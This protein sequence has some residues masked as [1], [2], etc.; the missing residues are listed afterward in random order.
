MNITNRTNN[1]T[2]TNITNS[3][4]NTSITNT[5][6]K[7]VKKT[8]NL[9]QCLVCFLDGHLAARK[10]NQKPGSVSHFFN[11]KSRGVKGGGVDIKMKMIG[12]ESN[13]LKF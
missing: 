13:F 6:P 12:S 2:T 8:V 7:W 5:V 10:H 4:N 1:T 11:R 3:T 9:D